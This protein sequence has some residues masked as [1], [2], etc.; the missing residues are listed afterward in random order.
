VKPASKSTSEESDL[1]SRVLS[2]G[3]SSKDRNRDHKGNIIDKPWHFEQTPDPG[4][5]VNMNFSIGKR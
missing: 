1:I 3:G 5:T 4:A 2:K